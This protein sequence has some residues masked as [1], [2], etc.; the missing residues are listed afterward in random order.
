[1]SH[2]I[3]INATSWAHHIKICDDFL[4]KINNLINSTKSTKYFDYF[5]FDQIIKKVENIKNEINS[6]IAKNVQDI[7]LFL[8]SLSHLEKEV[9]NLEYI[10]EN[11]KDEIVNN[12]LNIKE[13]NISEIIQ[14]HGTLAIEAIDYLK[15]NNIPISE[16]EIN[17]AIENIKNK[18]L[19]E[20]KRKEFL[21]FS[22][23]YIDDTQLPNEMKYS[24]K[25]EIRDV[26]THQDISDIIP[27]IESK[28]NEYK[29]FKLLVN[30]FNNILKEQGFKIDKNIKPEIS[31]DDY[32]N[33]VYKYRLINNSNNKVDI[34]INSEGKI[35]YKLGN[36]QGHM[37]NKTTEELF[38]KMK[39]L[40][41]N[42]DVIA[43]KRDIHNNKPL[44][45]EKELK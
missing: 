25:K 40:G 19:N 22:Y 10:V 20:I 27:L 30:D 1:M 32:S 26:N 29:R 33:M 21:N 8:S 36:Y 24:L 41:Y 2:T 43:I 7:Q 45:M 9:A 28:Q 18:A 12:I 13:L 11:K 3:T 42:L 15:N 44:E 23:K 4:E 37:C 5:N 16:H 35:K 39:Q 6:N 31:I 17:N 14:N 34:I 38:K